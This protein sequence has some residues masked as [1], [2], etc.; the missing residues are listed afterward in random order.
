VRVERHETKTSAWEL[1]RR[2]A[3]PGL[4][5]YLGRAL[6]GWAQ[7]RGIAPHFREVPFPGVPLI[8]S[9]ASPWVVGG[10]RL[11][12]FV[13]G[14]STSP[15]IVQGREQWSCV[16]L[17][18]TPLGAYRLLGVAMSDLVD[19]SVELEEVVPQV[20]ELEERLHESLAWADRFDL[21][22]RFFLRRLA[23][24]RAPDPGV[25]W[26]WNRLRVTR[27]RAPIR[28]LVEE[29]GWS[30]RRLVSRFREQVGL[31]PKRVARVI[32][33]DHAVAALRNGGDLAEIAYE[34]GYADQAHLNR[35]FGVLAG[36]TP[37]ALRAAG[38]ESGGL[39]A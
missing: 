25:E 31:S 5:P 33:F 15:T 10:R 39:A 18:L 7:T 14:L 27:G 29:L 22:E 11:E 21:V 1:A 20:R 6:E 13:A 30:H 24:S 34:C 32:R 16:E 37:T 28:G 2:D 38:L 3:S 17:R 8:L 12:S 9:V 35:E 36:T 23:D 4:R 19:E 26:S